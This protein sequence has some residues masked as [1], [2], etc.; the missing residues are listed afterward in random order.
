MNEKQIIESLEK[1]KF[2]TSGVLSAVLFYLYKK[3]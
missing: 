1:N 3:I 2:E